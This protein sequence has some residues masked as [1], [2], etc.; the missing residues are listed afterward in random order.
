VIAQNFGDMIDSDRVPG[1]ETLF[2]AT[3]VLHG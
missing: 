3:G 2:S 1:M